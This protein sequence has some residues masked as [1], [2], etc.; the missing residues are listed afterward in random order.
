MQGFKCQCCGN[1]NQYYTCITLIRLYIKHEFIKFIP[2]KGKV[3]FDDEL[4]EFD[5]DSLCEDTLRENNIDP[6]GIDIS[7]DVVGCHVYCDNCDAS[8]EVENC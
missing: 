2:A 8:F 1:V 5:I 4:S 7:F 6:F 3:L